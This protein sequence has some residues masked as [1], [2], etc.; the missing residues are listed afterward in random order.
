M[1]GVAASFE[2]LR[3]LCRPLLIGGSDGR[4]EL[5]GPIAHFA[6]QL[7]PL[8]EP[9][10]PPDPLCIVNGRLS[11]GGQHGCIAGLLVGFVCWPA[12]E[13]DFKRPVSDGADYIAS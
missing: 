2:L 8:V 3:R 7:I 4:I 11:D 5:A 10:L 13:D 9:A 1:A 12:P 6:A